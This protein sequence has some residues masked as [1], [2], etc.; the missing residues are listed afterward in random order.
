M[1]VFS[2]EILQKN[3]SFFQ[4]FV[5]KNPLKNLNN[6]FKMPEIQLKKKNI[7]NFSSLK[8]TKKRFF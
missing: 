2:K 3:N 7:T 5:K 4:Y 8:K 6:L 1:K